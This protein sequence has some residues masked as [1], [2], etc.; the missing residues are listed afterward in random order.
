MDNFIYNN[1]RLQIRD[2]LCKIDWII[3]KNIMSNKP[4]IKSF[5]TFKKT[6][7]KTEI[8]D[9]VSGQPIKVIELTYGFIGSFYL[10]TNNVKTAYNLYKNN[11]KLYDSCISENSFLKK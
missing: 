2:K 11:F 7:I 5:K 6:I 1:M 4:V 9:R 3:K 8:I 10:P